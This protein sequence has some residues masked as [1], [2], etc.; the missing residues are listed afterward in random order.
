MLY[1]YYLYIEVTIWLTKSIQTLASTV[2][3]VKANVHQAQSAK[4]MTS[5][6]STQI[7]VYLAEHVQVH[8]LAKLFLKSNSSNS[9][10]QTVSVLFYP[11]AVFFCKNSG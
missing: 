3:H 7:L 2:V 5:A 4:Q 1:F 11:E 10:K 8:V 6:L 9:L